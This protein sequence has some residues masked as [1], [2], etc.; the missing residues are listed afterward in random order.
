M[1]ESAG[2]I[3]VCGGKS[4]C[5]GISPRASFDGPIGVAGT[6]RGEL[7]HRGVESLPSTTG[8][9]PV[10][11]LALADPASHGAVTHGLR[12]HAGG[13]VG[14]H[15]HQRLGTVHLTEDP[16]TG[17]AVDTPAQ[18][19]DAVAGLAHEGHPHDH[20]HGVRRGGRAGVLGGGVGDDL[21]I[22]GGLHVGLD[23][24]A[25]VHGV[26]R[27][28]GRGRGAIVVDDGRLRVG[29]SV[30]V[31]RGA[32]ARGVT[33]TSGEDRDER[34]DPNQVLE[35]GGASFVRTTKSRGVHLPTA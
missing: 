33:A 13:Q 27:G 16:L 14:G 20:H 19:V 6:D 21:R 12:A 8:S 30:A 15:G 31:T 17:L 35:H 11:V 24:G 7:V 22:L 29:G 28:V 34:H 25:G 18:L 26:D 9:S 5:L 23:G 1:R 2:R 3:A 4:D 32:H 10:R